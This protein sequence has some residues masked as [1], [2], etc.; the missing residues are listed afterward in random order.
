VPDLILVVLP[1]IILWGRIQG[2]AEQP[3]D[4]EIA[5]SLIVAINVY[6]TFVTIF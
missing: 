6:T 2:F 3:F 5:Q 4:A 1:K